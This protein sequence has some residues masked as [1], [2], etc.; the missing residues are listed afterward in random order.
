MSSL[1]SFVDTT[2]VGGSTPSLQ[3]LSSESL[4]YGDQ[5]ALA[6]EQL[7]VSCYNLL[8][9]SSLA[10]TLPHL[11]LSSPRNHHPAAPSPHHRVTVSPH[12]LVTSSPHC[13][14]TL[15]PSHPVISSSS[16]SSPRPRPHLVLVLTSF[17][18]RPR[19]VSDLHIPLSIPSLGH[20][21]LPSP[22]P[23]P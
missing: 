13:F 5:E 12:Y 6:E 3:Y 16:S 17:S 8:S 1:S 19:L 4:V 10:S 21:I 18:F 23:D 22:V 7:A 14:I 11:I 20:Y 15:S 9:L 2:V